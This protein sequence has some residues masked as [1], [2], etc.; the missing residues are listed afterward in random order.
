M[1]EEQAASRGQVRDAG[2]I[3]QVSG[4][5]RLEAEPL[6]GALVSKA[7]FGCYS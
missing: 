6:T 4:L 7:Y 3:R 5:E 2:R 1:G